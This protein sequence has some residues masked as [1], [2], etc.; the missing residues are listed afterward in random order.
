MK[1]LES[2]GCLRPDAEG[3]RVRGILGSEAFFS[4]KRNL[5]GKRTGQ[6]VLAIICIVPL[7][8][9]GIA[10]GGISAFFNFNVPFGIAIISIII[11]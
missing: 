11:L 5:S 6:I 9:V 3:V 2:S 1:T 4:P 7:R 8:K 10:K